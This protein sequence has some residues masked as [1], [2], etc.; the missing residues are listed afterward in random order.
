MPGSCRSAAIEEGWL[1]AARNGA[2]LTNLKSCQPQKAGHIAA[3]VFNEIW[4]MKSVNE[5]IGG[6]SAESNISNGGVSKEMRK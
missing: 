5:N 3:T 2:K 4:R 1:A 6:V